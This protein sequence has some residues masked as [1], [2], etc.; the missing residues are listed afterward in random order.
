VIWRMVIHRC[1]DVK[2]GHHRMLRAHRLKAVGEFA[3]LSVT[4]LDVVFI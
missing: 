4:G 1:E 3:V 2:S